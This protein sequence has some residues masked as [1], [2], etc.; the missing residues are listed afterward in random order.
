VLN[1]PFNTFVG[2]TLRIYGILDIYNNV[3]AGRD[4]SGATYYQHVQA[5]IDASH[6]ARVS[7]SAPPESRSRPHRVTIHSTTDPA[8][9]PLTQAAGFL[10]SIPGGSGNFTSLPGAP[11]TAA[12]ARRVLWQPF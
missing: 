8:P 9:A 2:N 3:Q 12:R 10:T 7:L 6:T 1:F 5:G 4:Y 11:G